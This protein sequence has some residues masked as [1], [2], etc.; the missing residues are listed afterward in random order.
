M[1]ENREAEIAVRFPWTVMCPLSIEDNVVSKLEETMEAVSIVIAL[2]LA[3]AL[4]NLAE[5]LLAAAWVQ[6]VPLAA[7]SFRG[8]LPENPAYAQTDVNGRVRTDRLDLQ[9]AIGHDF[10]ELDIEDRVWPRRLER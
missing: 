2:V 10:A 7:R 1:L 3:F 8:F 5:Q 4:P 6:R 9:R